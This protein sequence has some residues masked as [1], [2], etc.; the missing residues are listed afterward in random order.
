MNT[1]YL[2]DDDRL[3][4][5][6]I[7]GFYWDAGSSQ[8]LVDKVQN[9]PIKLVSYAETTPV[10]FI[11]AEPRSKMLFVHGLYVEESYRRLGVGT[12][13]LRRLLL[14]S[15]LENYSEIFCDNVLPKARIVFMKLKDRLEHNPALKFDYN[16]YCDTYGYPRVWMRV[17]W[18]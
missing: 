3:P 12:L 11:A 17:E 14:K 16:F 13:M 18:K 2:K 8:S 1:V 5:E 9:S 7:Q 15:K 6:L 4:K 10:G